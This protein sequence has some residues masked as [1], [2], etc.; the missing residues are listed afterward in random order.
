M[1]VSGRTAET[2]ILV[3]L[4]LLYGCSLCSDEFRAEEVSPGGGRSAI[5]SIRNCGAA[6]SFRTQVIV[7]PRYKGSHEIEHVVFVARQRQ[8]IE[9][10]WSGDSELIVNCHTCRD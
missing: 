2:L 6:T 8:T 7:R 3:S 5:V 4:L 10:L 9:L 1:A